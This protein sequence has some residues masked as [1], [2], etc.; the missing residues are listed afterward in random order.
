MNLT[1]TTTTKIVPNLGKPACIKNHE[2]YTDCG[3]ACPLSCNSPSNQP[4][5]LQ[6]VPGCFCENGYVRDDRGNCILPEDCPQQK[7]LK[8]H[9]KYDGCNAHENCQHTCDKPMG[10]KCPR[11]CYSGCI[12]EAG[13]LRDAQWD[14]IP[15]SDC[16]KPICKKN[17]EERSECGVSI[18]EATCDDPDK[19]FHCK[20]PCFPGCGCKSGFVR[21]SNRNCI[22]LDQC[23]KPSCTKPHEFYTDC[24][25]ACP[26]S[27]TKPYVG[28]CTAQCVAGCFCEDGYVR[29][30]NEN[31]ILPQDCPNITC[32]GN[33]VYSE[34]GANG[35]QNTCD[36]PNLEQVCRGICIPG[37]VC[38]EGFVRDA[39]GICISQNLCPRTEC[40][41]DHEYYTDCGT[42]CPLYCNVPFVNFCTLQCVPGCFCEDGYF[43]D[44]NGNCVLPQDCPKIDCPE[45]EVYSDCEANGCQNTCENPN[46]S[47]LCDGMCIPGCV[48]EEGYIRDANGTCV[49]IDQCPK[50]SKAHEFYTDCGSACP[51]SCAEPSITFC[52]DQCVQGCFC[53]DGYVR[54]FNENCVLLEDCPKIDCSENEVY[55]ICGANGCQN[56]CEN[57][58]MSQLCDGLCIPGC[59]CAEGY[60]LD[61][62]GAC[63]SLDQCPKTECTREH[64]YYTDC[65]TACPLT[66]AKPSI[67]FCT[68]QCIQG[69][70]CE[71]GY[72]RDSDNN[73]ILPEN[74]PPIGSCPERE[75][76]SECGANDCQNSCKSPMFSFACQDCV[77]GCVCQENYVRDDNGTCVTLDEC[78]ANGEQFFS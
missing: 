53:E 20:A 16:P 38:E 8:K 30:D 18:C 15:K 11:K 54:D 57:P 21:D 10:G 13:F 37:C 12:C 77:S 48:C 24:G 74:C 69:C 5:T 26:L 70:F 35:C 55:S 17:N 66:C 47:Q 61:G 45:H 22:P 7:C 62:N 4:C 33:E 29:D 41:K 28:V 44:T 27:C 19:P 64:E 51:I 32:T 49:S 43:R 59:I 78:A 65:G 25:T 46:M 6:C 50:C 36:N 3:T 68:E 9:E 56:T 76:Y 40:T 73:C 75:V 72:V 63:V 1:T 2:V 67:E 14:C 42:A 60:V 71:D 58:D 39:N 23:P 34:C 31:C 52:T